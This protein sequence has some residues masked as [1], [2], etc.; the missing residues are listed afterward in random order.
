MDDQPRPNIPS[1]DEEQASGA[2]NGAPQAKMLSARPRRPRAASGLLGDRVEAADSKVDTLPRIGKNR[3]RQGWWDPASVGRG[4][5]M[6]ILLL[7]AIAA[8]VAIVSLRYALRAPTETAISWS[9][10]S[11]PSGGRINVLQI[12]PH[13]PSIV[14]AG[15]DGG[16]CDSHDG[17]PVHRTYG[18]CL[19]H[20]SRQSANP[21]HG[22]LCRDISK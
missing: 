8:I 16:I 12:N 7:T 10:T 18:H 21:I 6:A 9:Q 20:R 1:P 22:Y 19:G 13:N 11:G 2:D 3:L 5:M 14:Y 4:G 15:T 17:G